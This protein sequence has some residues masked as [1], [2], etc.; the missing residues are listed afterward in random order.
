MLF[1]TITD[2]YPFYKK[3]KPKIDWEENDFKNN[4]VDQETYKKNISIYIYNQIQELKPTCKD[5]ALK[6]NL[7]LLN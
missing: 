7:A 2:F 4:S 3:K 1:T 5:Q 6:E